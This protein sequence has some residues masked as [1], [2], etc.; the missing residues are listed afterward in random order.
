MVGMLEFS[1]CGLQD[2]FES[3]VSGVSPCWNFQ[4]L[5]Q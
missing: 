4:R 5:E 2:W 1:N 3:A